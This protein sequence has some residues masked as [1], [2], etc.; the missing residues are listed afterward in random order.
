MGKMA[1][2]PKGAALT[3]PKG[4]ALLPIFW[5]LPV[6]ITGC[7]GKNGAKWVLTP[8]GPTPGPPPPWGIQKVL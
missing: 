6:E 3:T 5:A 8:M 1:A 4:L 2:D 7:E